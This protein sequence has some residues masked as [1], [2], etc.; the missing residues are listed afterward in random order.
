MKYLGLTLW[1]WD[2]IV[3]LL[4]VAIAIFS[5]VIFH[6]SR[7]KAQRYSLY[8]DLMGKIA[9]NTWII[10]IKSQVNKKDVR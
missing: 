10:G 4:V 7:N 5:V 6:N 3:I 9:L 1:Q 2:V 8:K